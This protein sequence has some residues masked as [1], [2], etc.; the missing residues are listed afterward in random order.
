MSTTLPSLYQD[1]IHISRYARFNDALGRR[2]TWEETVDRYITFFQNKVQNGKKVPWEELRTAILNLE[3]MPSMRCLMTAG[4]ALEKDQVAGYNC[5]YIAVDNSK[6]FDE[7][8]YILMCFHPDTL[9]K[10]RNGPVAISSMQIGDEV[11]SYNEVTKN[12]VW[13]PITNVV[14]TPSAHLEK[15]KITLENGQEILCTSNHKWL[16]ENRGWIE[17]GNLTVDD[18]LIAPKF[19]VYKSTN[20][21]NQKSYVGYTSKTVRG[22]FIQHL[23][24]ARS[25]SGKYSSHF[26]RAIRKHG[27]VC[28]NNEILDYAY[29]REEAKQ[30][31]KDWIVLLD[32]KE[33]GY[34]S[35]NG[36]DGGGNTWSEEAKQKAR[37]NSYER[38]EEHRTKQAEVIK[39]AHIKIH[40]TRKTEKYREA[41]RLRN[42]G[43][44]NPRYG[45]T[46]T[47]EERRIK[48]EQA[49]AR[50]RSATGR[51]V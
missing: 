41:Q 9:V 22:R 1:F 33:N 26:H 3:V 15:V 29:T 50:T 14:E 19:V 6:S 4:P 25:N 40:E 12:F 35:S 37:E 47:E 18:D 34:N 10:T 48:S 42:L 20:T 13:R 38:T 27:E 43:S 5:S 51:F 7:I 24:E 39:K 31:E 44:N 23:A 2:E 28:W 16:T 36:G 17:A 46:A 32:S 11:L 8:M 45:C 49:K 21:N 30:K